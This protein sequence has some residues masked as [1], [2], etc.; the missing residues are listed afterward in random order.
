MARIDL[1]RPIR[2][3]LLFERGVEDVEERLAFP[4]IEY[5]HRDLWRGGEFQFYGFW[6]EHPG[7]GDYCCL[8]RCSECGLCL[9]VGQE[10]GKLMGAAIKIL[11]LVVPLLSIIFKRI[12]F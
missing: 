3:I 8:C 1:P 5:H 4:I 2:V 10:G 7:C 6:T 9:P 12:K 11:S